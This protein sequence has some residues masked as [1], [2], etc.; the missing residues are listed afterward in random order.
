MKIDLL[1]AYAVIVITIP[2]AIYLFVKGIKI[3][4]ETA[5]AKLNDSATATPLE[6]TP[7]REVMISE[8]PI[9]DDDQV[10][11]I[12]IKVRR[13]RLQAPQKPPV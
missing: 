6:I 9:D 4:I 11:R 7:P 1:L 10:I 5:K 8:I 3:S 13:K 12:P 2:L